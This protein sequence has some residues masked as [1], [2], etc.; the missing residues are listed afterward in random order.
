MFLLFCILYTLKSKLRHL[1]FW[2]QKAESLRREL[3]GKEKELNTSTEILNTRER[4]SGQ[5]ISCSVDLRQQLFCLLL[6]SLG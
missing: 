2:L 6:L 1:A 3:E 4:V 5:C